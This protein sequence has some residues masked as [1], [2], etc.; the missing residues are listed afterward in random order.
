M[1]YDEEILEIA[2][3]MVMANRI[4]AIDP[5]DALYNAIQHGISIGPR[6]D[7]RD[8]FIAAA[9]TGLCAHPSNE[10]VA[11]QA[12]KVADAVLAKLEEEGKL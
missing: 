12:I 8:R 7:R 11:T 9:L 1:G 10:P 2:K 6:N 5:V 3:Q 4:S